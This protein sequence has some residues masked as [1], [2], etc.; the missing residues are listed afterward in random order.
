MPAIVVRLLKREAFPHRFT[1]LVYTSLLLWHDRRGIRQTPI[2]EATGDLRNLPGSILHTERELKVPLIVVRIPVGSNRLEQQEPGRRCIAHLIDATV[3]NR[4]ANE[5]G[6]GVARSFCRACA[7]C[8]QAVFRSCRSIASQNV[9]STWEG[10][11]VTRGNGVGE[12]E[13]NGVGKGID[14]DVGKSPP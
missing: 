4:D 13:G 7:Y 11:G 14:V 1:P 8:P 2:S 10:P 9:V 5:E 3:D 6:W 12:G